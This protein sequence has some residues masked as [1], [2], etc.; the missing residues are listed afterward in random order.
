MRAE[1]KRKNAEKGIDKEPTELQVGCSLYWQQQ[2]KAMLWDK[3]RMIAGRNDLILSCG[4][5]YKD[6]YY[7]LESVGIDVFQTYRNNGIDFEEQ[8]IN[9]VVMCSLVGKK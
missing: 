6:K 5:G 1:W 7:S 8:P 3:I 4:S 2:V 9:K